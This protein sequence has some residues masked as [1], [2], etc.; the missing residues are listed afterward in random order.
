MQI[1]SGL[2]MSLSNILKIDL[3]LSNNGDCFFFLEQKKINNH[4]KLIKGFSITK[5]S[6]IFSIRLDTF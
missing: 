4:S 5:A 3:F 2:E 6:N 1:V